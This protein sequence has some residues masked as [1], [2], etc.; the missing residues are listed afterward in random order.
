MGKM[1]DESFDGVTG[2]GSARAPV[3]PIG[4]L[5]DASFDGEKGIGRASAPVVVLIGRK[6]DSGVA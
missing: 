5:E 6:V 2:I 1:E 4:K 3:P